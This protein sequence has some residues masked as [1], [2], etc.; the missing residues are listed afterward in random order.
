M[1]KKRI[2]ISYDSLS[3]KKNSVE[4]VKEFLDQDFEITLREVK[5]KALEAYPI[6]I[7]SL[8]G[9]PIIFFSAGFF[10]KIGEELGKKVG[11]DLASKYEA[12]KSKLADLLFEKSNNKIPLLQL[13]LNK[14]NKPEINIYL[15]TSSKKVIIKNLDNIEYFYNHVL[16]YLKDIYG[17]EKQGKSV[18][19]KEVLR[20][21]YKQLQEKKA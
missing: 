4:E 2:V 13:K 19:V 20:I 11:E 5:Q 12:F 8:I 1:N 14:G 17:G 6:I 15:K 7:I 16:E 3:Y 21:F 18:A 9:Q 10:T